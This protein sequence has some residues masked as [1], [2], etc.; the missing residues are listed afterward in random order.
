[1]FINHSEFLSAGIQLPGALDYDQRPGGL[2]PRR[3]PAWTRPQVP[4][5]MNTI[6]RM[7]S[8]VR[9]SLA[10]DS[11]FIELQVQSTRIFTPPA[12]PRAVSFDLMINHQEIRHVQ[13][14]AG[15]SIKLNP[16][17]PGEFELIRG[18]AYTIRFDDL[19]AGEN[20]YELW[21]PHN[22]FL[23]IRSVRLASNS[24]VRP[25]TDERPSWLHY[26]SSISH[27][28]EADSPTGTWPAVAAY[29]GAQQ[30]NLQSFG[31]A[32]QCQLDQFVARA[33]RDLPAD[34]I[35]L[36]IGINLVNIDSMR[37]RVFPSALHGFLD[38]LREGQA[39]TPIILVS[40]IYCP[41]A[42]DNPGPTIPDETGKFRTH[43]GDERLRQ[44]ALSLKRV[45]QLMTNLVLQRTESGDNNLYYLDGLEL[46]SE[47]DAADLPDLLHPN[48]AGYRRMGERF[49]ARVFNGG[50][51]LGSE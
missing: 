14:D 45:R 18:E 23:E 10:T 38:T 34:L 15:N 16:A 40:P 21:L 17:K 24:V 44:G 2:S 27:C 8:G 6:V 4:E 31:F 9:L 20:N 29:A 46:F 51:Y 39:Q 25:V 3:L 42:E 48:P 11:P 33:M 47:A 13:V 35:T 37:E 28:M 26:G 41:S 12:A 22:A 7:P 36:K 5:V 19:P 1:M 49:A 30:V 43:K 50:K 32:G